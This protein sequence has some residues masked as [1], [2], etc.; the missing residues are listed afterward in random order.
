MIQPDLCNQ[1]HKRDAQRVGHLD[2]AIRFAADE[3][4][5]TFTGHAAVFGER[6]SFNEIVKPGA[7]TRTLADY[8]ARNLRPPML[9]SHRADEV[10]GVWADVREDRTGLAVT[11]QLITETA[12]GK[13]A[14][15]LLKAGALS[16]LSIGF[17][18]KQATRDAN[19]VR[20]LSQI[21][22]VEISLVAIPAA[23]NARITH[24]RAD[25]A[26]VFSRAVASAIASLKG[27]SK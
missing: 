26:A 22:L 1:L 17:R 16:G 13:E 9:W 19:G 18:A 7:F 5:G 15:A 6:N 11:G 10:I 23:G 20:I 25:N 21:D 2:Y 3:S 24:V 27:T 8:H 4:A 14:H 12:R